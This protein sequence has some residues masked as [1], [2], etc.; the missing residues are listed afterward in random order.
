LIGALMMAGGVGITA[1]AEQSNSSSLTTILV[2]CGSILNVGA[3]GLITRVW[4][5]RRE[6]LGLGI[7]L[8]GVSLL[9]FDGD[10]RANPTGVATQFVALSCWALGTALSRKLEIASGAMG[11][12]S[13]MLIGGTVLMAMSAL[14][15]EQ[16]PLFIPAR[17]IAAW[18]YLA[19]F[20]SVVAYTAYVYLIKHARPALATS[21]SYINPI[22]AI[23]L[24]YAVLGERVSNI[25][26]L[27]M[28]IVVAGVALM[29]LSRKATP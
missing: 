28:S 11:S 14:R 23:V 20:G 13:Q 17:A 15:A 18:I 26:L 24:G 21:Y 29:S 7:G 25:A 16:L 6:W 2:A 10:V 1:Y 27:S 3:V 8:I 4:P 5:V 12:A 22:V 9:A 19:L